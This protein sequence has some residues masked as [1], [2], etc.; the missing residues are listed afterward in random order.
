MRNN[1]QVSIPQ[2]IR[3]LLR[4]AINPVLSGSLQR[5]PV[6]FA[7]W[8]ATI[9]SLITWPEDVVRIQQSER[10]KRLSLTRMMKLLSQINYVFAGRT[11]AEHARSVL[12]GYAVHDW[13]SR[14]V[15][16][17]ASLASRTHAAIA[18]S[19]DQVLE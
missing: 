14:N 12:E 3:W 15:D 10:A 13:V 6:A 4:L 11:N 9:G 16:E 2:A 5:D 1:L 18:L 7:A 17:F 8:Y 19:D